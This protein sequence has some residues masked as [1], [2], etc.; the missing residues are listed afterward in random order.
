MQSLFNIQDPGKGLIDFRPSVLIAGAM[1]GGTTAF[2]DLAHAGMF[3]EGI[4]MRLYMAIVTVPAFIGLIAGILWQPTR[5]H[6]IYPQIRKLPVPKTGKDWL[7]AKPLMVLGLLIATL[8]WSLPVIFKALNLQSDALPWFQVSQPFLFILL[9]H[10]I[11]QW[12][13]SLRDE[14][15]FLFTGLMLGVMVGSI[16]S[17]ARGSASES[18]LDMVYD[19]GGISRL[20]LKSLRSMYDSDNDGFPTRFCSD[21]CDCDDTD[22]NTNP[23]AV[24]IIGN[25]ID[26][27]CDHYDLSPLANPKPKAVE[28]PE[29][30][31]KPQ[32]HNIILIVM[33]TVRADHLGMYGYH[34]PTSPNMDEL[35]KRSRVFT[36]GRSQG[37]NTGVSL[38]SLFTGKYF[39]EI[40]RTHRKVIFLDESNETMAEIFKADGYHTWAIS[41]FGYFRKTFGYSQ[42]FD[43]FDSRIMKIR[44]DVYHTKTS[45]LVTKFALDRI[46]KWQDQSER[47]FLMVAHYADPHV[48]Y[49]DH[50]YGD[51]FK[52][53]VLP[54]YDEEIRYVD[55]H[56]GVLFDGLKERG[57]MNDTVIIIT[58]DHGEGL[59]AKRDHGHR[60]H[61]QHVYDNL[62]HVPFIIWSPNGKPGV[63]E[64]PVGNVDILPTILKLT[65]VETETKLSG[66]SL[67]PFLQGKSFD[68]G[69]IFMEKGYPRDKIK[70]AMLDWPYKLHWRPAHN[71]WELYD[72]R[73]D[74][75]EKKTLVKSHPKIFRK[76]KKRFKIWRA[77]EL[78]IKKMR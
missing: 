28:P 55:D 8:A 9:Y 74:S 12:A 39:S 40:A 19:R 6:L 76:L 78:D 63:T 48:T 11:Y 67:V 66:E 45:D 60:Y 61:G 17:S 2:I 73:T 46:D 30:T 43:E 50:D 51:L 34:L 13:E 71:R 37:P 49:V 36:Q 62:V 65:G 41:S 72:L 47:P 4:S 38:P 14:N 21:A 24:E 18:G 68:R 1:A 15:N 16:L 77:S 26:E 54:R 44:K 25:G 33:D 59:T 23:G 52:K 57:I 42:G 3:S 29:E 69:P 70:F 20:T 10:G 64:T 32:R 5:L 27:D 31:F 75:G 22:K 7:R 53:A 35:A 58:S 56:L